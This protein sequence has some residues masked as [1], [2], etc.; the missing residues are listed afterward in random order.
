MTADTFVNSRRITPQRYYTISLPESTA[1]ENKLTPYGHDEEDLVFLMDGALGLTTS[2]G[3][4]DT[5]APGYV[6]PMPPAPSPS[7]GSV[8]GESDRKGGNA[9]DIQDPMQPFNRSLAHFTTP[10]LLVSPLTFSYGEAL[11]RDPSG[12]IGKLPLPNSGVKPNHKISGNTSIDLGLERSRTTVR[13]LATAAY[14]NSVVGTQTSTDPNAWR[15]GGEIDTRFSR[16]RLFVGLFRESQFADPPPVSV[17]ANNATLSLVTPR[18]DYRYVNAGFE[19]ERPLS[20]QWVSLSP[21][22]FSIATG[23]SENEITAVQLAGVTFGLTD[24]LSGDMFKNF[25][26]PLTNTAPLNYVV[27][28]LQ[29]TRIQFDITPQV[30]VPYGNSGKNLTLK[31]DATYYRYIGPNENL[32][33]QQTWLTTKVTLSVPLTGRNGQVTL[34]LGGT[35]TRA[36]VVGFTTPIVV[37]QPTIGLND[38]LIWARHNGWVF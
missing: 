29:R 23:M 28:S 27:Q 37:W 9:R 35:Y 34:D 13:V 10:Y 5:C 30:K 19:L 1:L 20:W 22:R 6:P 11:L 26:S 24:Y 8:P 33:S 18:V 14:G 12:L 4:V 36:S 17:K 7:G 2:A 21:L 32:L 15:A 3:S 38:P 31:V 25:K 16:G